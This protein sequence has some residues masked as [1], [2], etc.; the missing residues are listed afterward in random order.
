MRSESTSARRRAVMG[1]GNAGDVMGEFNPCCLQ[2][3][4]WSSKDAE[5]A[6]AD[7][8]ATFTWRVTS[9]VGSASGERELSGERG[10]SLISQ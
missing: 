5:E 6:A 1:T 10:E 8:A 4:S 3:S 7:D 9:A 2:S